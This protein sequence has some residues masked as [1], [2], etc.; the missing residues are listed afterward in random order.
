MV[1]GIPESPRHLCKVGRSEEAIE[2]LS[3]VWDKPTDHEDIVREHAEII[4]ALRVESEH[5]EYE[6]KSIFKS[7]RVKT[8]RRVLLAYGVNFINQ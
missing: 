7:D 2:V 3:A 5:G 8:G 4:E 1:F 6:W